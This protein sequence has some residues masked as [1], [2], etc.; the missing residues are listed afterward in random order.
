[1]EL[2]K[3]L[4]EAGNISVQQLFPKD[5]SPAGKFDGLIVDLDDWGPDMR[6]TLVDQITRCPLPCPIVLHSYD[7]DGQ[8]DALQVK[9]VILCR[10][11]EPELFRL[12]PA[13]ATRVAGS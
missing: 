13:A 6:A 9:G 3:E 7:L 1:L 11:L 5:G 8:G 2:P 4:G 10:R 12:L